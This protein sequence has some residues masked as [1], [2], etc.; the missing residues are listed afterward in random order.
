MSAVDLGA[1]IQLLNNSGHLVEIDEEVDWKFEIGCIIRRIF[2]IRGGGPA[3]L[4][5]NIKGYR[6]KVGRK[7][8]AGSFSSYQRIAMIMGL[9][10]ETCYQELVSAYLRGVD[11][12]IPPVR[13]K[14]GPCKE[15][16]RK[17]KRVDLLSFPVP[18]LHPLD[19]GRFMGTFHLVVTKDPE[20]GLQ[21]VGMYRM[22]VHDRNHLG[23]LFLSRQ[24]W[25]IH[26]R[27][28]QDRG[29]KMP[30]AVCF[31]PPQI[32][33]LTAMAKLDH[34]PD[35]FSYA[36]GM[37]G[38]AIELVQ[39]ETVDL[40]VPA[41]S[42]IVLEGFVDMDPESF[43]LEG[44]FG[45]YMGYMAGNAVMRPVVEVRCITHREDP[46]LQG[47]LEG[48][49]VPGANEDH[50][51]ASIITA[52]YAQRLLKAHNIAVVAVAAPLGAH[53]FNKVIVSIR[54]Q[55]QGEAMQIASLLWGSR[56]SFFRFKEVV[57][58]DEDIDVY[59]PDMVEFAVATR[60]DPVHDITVVDGFPGIP[61]DPRIPPAEKQPW[62]GGGRWSRVCIDA[63]RPFTWPALEEWGGKRFPPVQHWPKELED[64]VDAKW[65][66]YG[67]GN[68]PLP[69]RWQNTY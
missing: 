7:F 46:I 10:P 4:F 69:P 62:M 19:G 11:N 25:E 49:C 17:N 23:T 30:I 13:V 44:P 24:D 37:V 42:E 14:S 29:K 56:A 39:C 53:G 58:V 5:N 36:G 63:T 54:Q 66:K 65:K 16:I 26:S 9:P 3:V 67:L 59:N 21:N 1:W 15:V 40:E 60:V 50:Y 48:R 8:F 2:D 12:P 34:P 51:G 55:R 6:N 43:R 27:K 20:T 52:G 35:E 32:T 28:W 61:L 45:E 22:M 41:Q 68:Y 31:G 18:H 47:T 64:M 57:V 33:L 38:E